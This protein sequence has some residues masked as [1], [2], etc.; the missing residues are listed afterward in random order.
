MRLY[1]HLFPASSEYNCYLSLLTTI[2][3]KVFKLNEIKRIC[4]VHEGFN[5]CLCANFDSYW[6]YFTFGRETRYY[7]LFKS[8]FEIFFKLL[9]QVLSF[10]CFGNS[11][12]NLLIQFVTVVIKFSCTCGELNILKNLVM[13]QI[14]MT[15]ILP[16]CHDHQS[17][18]SYLDFNLVT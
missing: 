3:G 5:M 11:S 16:K 2:N 13:L 8:S 15:M 7:S 6:Q 18:R 9:Q 14:I 17:E 1:E 4:K 12:I 10:S